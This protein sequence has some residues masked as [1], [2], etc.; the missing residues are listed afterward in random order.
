MKKL[1]VAVA[2]VFTSSTGFAEDWVLL[3]KK[4]SATVLLQRTDLQ[5]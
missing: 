4:G 1:L 3:G 5:G 2:L